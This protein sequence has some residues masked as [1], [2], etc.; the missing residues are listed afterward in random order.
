MDNTQPSKTFSKDVINEFL[1]S[2]KLI[3]KEDLQRLD[4]IRSIVETSI[5][6]LKEAQ[7]RMHSVVERF[8]NTQIKYLT[9]GS[10]NIPVDQLKGSL[11]CFVRDDLCYC[12]NFSTAIW[13][14]QDIL[15]MLNA[16]DEKIATSMEI[17]KQLKNN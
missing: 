15:Y 2:L 10:A 12:N 7:K 9:R 14:L 5:N 11:L 4:E 16:V 17:A 13:R 1:D 3:F 6:D 8:D